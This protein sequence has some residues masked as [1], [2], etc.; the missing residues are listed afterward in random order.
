MESEASVSN[1]LTARDHLEVVSKLA[2]ESSM[3]VNAKVEVSIPVKGV[4]IGVGA[5]SNTSSTFSS[6]METTAQ[7]TVESTT[8]AASALR[9]Q[10]KIRIEVARENR[11]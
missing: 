8:E 1:R 6:V 9:S 10:R 2:A 5:G 4:P 7:R 3:G 11:Q